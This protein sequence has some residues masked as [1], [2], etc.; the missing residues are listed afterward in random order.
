MTIMNT[1]RRLLA[2]AGLAVTLLSMS[3]AHADEAMMNAE[4]DHLL[5]TVAGSDCVFIRNGDEHDAAAA[6]DHLQM[7]RERGRRYYD[8]TEQFIERIASRSSWSGKD[9]HIRCG[10]EPEQAA[11]DWF[12]AVLEKYRSTAAQ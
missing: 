1:A 2:T 8:S 10:A 4:I 9:Y 5:E 6:R 11:R 7:K 3:A 12:T